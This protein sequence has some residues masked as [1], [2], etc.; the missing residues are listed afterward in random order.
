[1]RPAFYFVLW[2]IFIVF[3]VLNILT[4]IVVEIYSIQKSRALQRKEEEAAGVADRSHVG[5]GGGQPDSRASSP[6][7]AV[8]I[9]AEPARDVIA[10]LRSPDLPIDNGFCP[11]CR[12]P[13]DVSV[14]AERALED[15]EWMVASPRVDTSADEN[16][17]E[18]PSFDS[19][20]T[21]DTP[22]TPD[23]RS[24]STESESAFGSGLGR[25]RV[26][27]RPG[28]PAPAHHRWSPDG[29]SSRIEFSEA[30]A[31]LRRRAQ[32]ARARSRG[33]DS[34]GLRHPRRPRI[35]PRSSPRSVGRSGGRSTIPRPRR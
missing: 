27:R 9:R 32:V 17:S 5:P 11:T 34:P 6:E 35:H 23:T 28:G 10:R 15:L 25:S 14:E 20:D 12:R 2:F 29:L 31:D 18:L 7:G 22:D 4:A 24:M 19:Y 1:M 16:P 8:K 26:R 30:D 13:I 3:L 33:L 21:P